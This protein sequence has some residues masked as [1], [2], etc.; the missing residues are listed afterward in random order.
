[1]RQGR[2]EDVRLLGKVLSGRSQPPP[3]PSKRT[4]L[5][6]EKP[7]PTRLAVYK[8]DTDEYHPFSILFTHVLTLVYIEYSLV[9]AQAA[10]MDRSRHWLVD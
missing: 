10:V 8:P 2:E 6:Y 5:T 7:A 4:L 1:M 3:F 9:Q